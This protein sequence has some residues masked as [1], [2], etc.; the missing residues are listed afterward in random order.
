M[1]PRAGIGGKPRLVGLKGRPV[2]EPLMVIR[3][4]DRPLLDG[5]MTHPLSDGAVFIDVAFRARFSVS[6]RAGI[7]RVGKYVVDGGV[8]G[9]QPADRTRPSSRSLLQGE[10]QTFRAKPEPPGEPNQTRRSARRPCRSRR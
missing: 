5:K 2:D 1:W 6:V 4:E 3:D 7:Y 10:R 9:G 8:S